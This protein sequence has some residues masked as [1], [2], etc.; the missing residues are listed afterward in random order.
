[1]RISGKI[2]HVLPLESGESAKGTWFKRTVVVEKKSDDK[3]KKSV[4]V[5]VWS[6]MAEKFNFVVGSEIDFE[7]D[8]ESREYNGRWFTDVKA[9]RINTDSNNN[10]SSSA[11]SSGEK[12]DDSDLPF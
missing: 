12:V 2:T 3:Y 8:V 7:I 10:S 9:F 4:A 11:A 6:D 1:M 5:T